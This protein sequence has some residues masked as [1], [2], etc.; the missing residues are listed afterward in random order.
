MVPNPAA[1]PVPW[2]AVTH[3]GEEGRLRARVA[4]FE[5]RVRELEVEAAEAERTRHA[6]A[7]SEE[8]FRLAFHTSPDARRSPEVASWKESAARA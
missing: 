2:P 1:D 8:R 6:L 7:P 4:A 5:Q 3:R